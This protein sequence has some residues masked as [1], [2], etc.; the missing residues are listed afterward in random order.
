VETRTAGGDRADHRGRLVRQRLAWDER[1]GVHRGGQASVEGNV[2]RIV[3][4]PGLADTP[5]DNLRVL[6]FLRAW[7]PRH[8]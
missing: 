7:A 4:K 8:A 3:G 1:A 2:R 5:Q 6:A